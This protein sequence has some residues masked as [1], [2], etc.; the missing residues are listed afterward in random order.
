[1]STTDLRISNGMARQGQLRERVLAEGARHIGWKAGLGTSAALAKLG[2]TAPLVGFLTDATQLLD[3]GTFAI[4]GLANPRL[5]PEV[6]VRLG[7]SI[8]PS[9]T[10][11]EV[12]NAVEAVAPAIEI[13]DLG[14]ADDVEEVLAGNIFHQS[15]LVGPFTAATPATFAD[16]RVSVAVNGEEV[17]ANVDPGTLLGRLEDILGGMAWQVV[18]ATTAGATFSAG[19]IVITGSVVTALELAGGEAVT[20]S[21]A[22]GDAVSVNIE[23]RA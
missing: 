6:A 5:E 17:H 10:P 20:V 14:A 15:F 13:V 2:T 1:V 11:S 21:L 16:A 23:R 3:G 4:D 7:A 9:A 12:L 8:G 19:D 22:N 18:L